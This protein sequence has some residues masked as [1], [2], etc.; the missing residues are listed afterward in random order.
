MTFFLNRNNVFNSTG[1]SS[2][3]GNT[4][5]DITVTGL[6]TINDLKVTGS[7]Q[8]SEL[9]VTG[10]EVVDGN[11]NV[12]GNTRVNDL[13]IGN[14]VSSV[15]GN[16]I[17]LNNPFYQRIRN[18]ATY[19]AS[20]RILTGVSDGSYSPIFGLPLVSGLLPGYNTSS[21]VFTPPY[22]GCYEVVARIDKLIITTLATRPDNFQGPDSGWPVYGIG[23][24]QNNVINSGP[25]GSQ[26]VL[27][28]TGNFVY[29][30]LAM[31][32]TYLGRLLPGTDTLRLVAGVSRKPTGNDGS[33]TCTITITI[34]YLG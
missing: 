17:F 26:M 29:Q 23:L 30:V 14:T 31:N 12:A 22:D 9:E 25:N 2:G 21:G 8:I 24:E 28:S 32:A 18:F 7:A 3:G 27:S 15:S 34:T 1:S 13:F 20:G 19:S 4:F 16:P 5:V 11:L 33:N 6:A 10:D